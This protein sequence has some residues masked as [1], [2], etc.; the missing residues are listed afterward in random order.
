MERGSA[1]DVPWTRQTS[2]FRR[3]SAKTGF[4]SDDGASKLDVEGAGMVHKEDEEQDATAAM[5]FYACVGAF[6]AFGD[7]ERGSRC[8]GGWRRAQRVREDRCGG[9]ERGVYSGR[10][11]RRARRAL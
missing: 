8:A 2:P 11:G 6:F 5:A 7:G 3:A 10:R 4:C 9:A 1:R